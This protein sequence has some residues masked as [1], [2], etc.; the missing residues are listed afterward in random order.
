MTR[1][2]AR[3]RLTRRCSTDAGP[4]RTSA[5]TSTT[6]AAGSTTGVLVMPSGSTL[7]QPVTSPTSVNGGP[8][9]VDQSTRPDPESGATPRLR[10]V[11]AS[12][13]PSATSGWPYTAAPSSV[14][15][16]ARAGTVG[17]PPTAP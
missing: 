11:A 16:A 15:Q 8:T 9:V 1:P 17:P 4:V 10:S 2:V 7:P 3:S 14:R 13:R 5:T 6:C 12:T